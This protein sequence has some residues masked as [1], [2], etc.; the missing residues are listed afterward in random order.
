MGSPLAGR[1]VEVADDGDKIRVILDGE[2]LQ[3]FAA[4][5]P[6]GYISSGRPLGRPPKKYV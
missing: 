3:A 6:K 1:T 2:Q 5:T 4:D